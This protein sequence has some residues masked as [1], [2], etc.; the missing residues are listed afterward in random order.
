MAFQI[1]TLQD[2]LKR[3]LAYAEVARDRLSVRRAELWIALCLT[4]FFMLAGGLSFSAALV[5]LT[6]V[7]AWAA[8]I[9]DDK[10]QSTRMADFDQTAA[11]SD[12]LWRMMVDAVPEPAV[13]LDGSGQILHA[14]RL[15]EEL[16]GTRRRG[17]HIASMTRDPE[18]LAAVDEALETRQLR[19]VELHRRVPVERRLLATLA[20]L[21][22]PRSGVDPSL[23]ISFRDLTEQDRLARMRAD[24]VANASHELRTPLASLRGFVETLQG[25]AKNDTEARERFLKVMSEQAERMSRLVD[26]LLSL[27]RV[28]M[29]E[30]LPPAQNVDLNDAVSHVI[31]AL[32]PLAAGTATSIEFKRL[33]TPAIV[34]GDR[35]ELVQVF[36]N[37]VQN[38]IK[39]GKSGGRIEVAVAFAEAVGGRPARFV[40]S[41]TDDGPGIAA[42]HLPRL[43]ERFYRVNVLASRE[44][45]GTGLGL[46]IVKH[47]LNRHRG[48]LNINSK[49]GEGSTFSVVLPALS[50]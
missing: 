41:V 24:F 5:G 46:A 37:L 4:I 18:L 22:H 29:R 42:Q 12:R 6:I 19:E 43:T 26:D 45:G 9:A 21:D 44:R 40:V 7:V 28:E 17:G 16:F 11:A 50:G 3:L 15:A 33:D 27:S 10:R 8:L 2:R 23:L 30:H 1:D 49:V 39:Y 35:D 14:N 47:I 36:Q 25:A 32:Q 38:A 13:A 20:P 31:Q 48:E 34:R